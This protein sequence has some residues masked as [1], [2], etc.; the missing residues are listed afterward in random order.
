[1]LFAPK[2]NPSELAA[3][4]DYLIETGPLLSWTAEERRLLLGKE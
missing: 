1:L 4:A 2:A 3:L